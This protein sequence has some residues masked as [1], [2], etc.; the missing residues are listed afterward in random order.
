MGREVHSSRVTVDLELAGLLFSTRAAEGIDP[1]TDPDINEPDVFQHLLPGCAR[2]TTG[3]SGRPEI[4]VPDRRL[5][6]GFAVCDVSELEPSTWTQDAVDFR[7][8]RLLVSAKVD[9][10]I[11]NDDVRPPV[12]DW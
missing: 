4:D 1:R 12:F 9:D 10:A 8:C 5:G 6:Y 3:N 7:E 11:A 2:Q